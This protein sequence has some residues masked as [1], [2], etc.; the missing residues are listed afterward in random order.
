MNNIVTQR[1]DL[2]PKKK[3]RL[4][5][6]D[7]ETLDALLAKP[8]PEE[9]T[10]AMEEAVKKY[11]ENMQS[12]HY[13]LLNKPNMTP[14]DKE[15]MQK[16]IQYLIDKKMDTPENFK[17]LEAIKYWT[18]FIEIGG[19]RFSREKLIPQAQFKSEPNQY[20]VFE[21]DK[22][23]I[24]KTNYNGKDE[25]YFTTDAYIQEA[26]KQGKTVIEYYHIRS[27]LQELPGEFINK[28]RYRW[29]NIL[30][31]ILNMSQSGFVYSD[32]HW[33]NEDMFGYLSS[34]YPFT[35]SQARAFTFGKDEG[36]L[37]DDGRNH[38]RPC[39]FVVK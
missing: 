24:F 29:A 10:P 34:A 33:W 15:N 16:S 39:L 21:S 3:A 30:W 31:N 25:Y 23:G 18:N 6:Y 20:D 12:P 38:A 35:K 27:A 7:Q 4:G 8:I 2:T 11:E 28:D 13:K 26:Q 1:L 36:R 14:T 37:N 22:E 32:G 17:K 5:K 19:V 9:M